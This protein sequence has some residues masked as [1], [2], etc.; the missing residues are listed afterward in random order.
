[1]EKEVGTQE[2]KG[3]V[4]IIHV[5]DIYAYTNLDYTESL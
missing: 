3:W 5:D 1:M 4:L 2:N